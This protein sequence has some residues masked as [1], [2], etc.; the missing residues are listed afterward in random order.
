M[1]CGSYM[2][3]QPYACSATCVSLVI[4]GHGLSLLGPPFP[5]SG[6]RWIGSLSLTQPAFGII[7]PSPPQP[8]ILSLSSGRYKVSIDAFC[9]WKRVPFPCLLSCLPSMSH[10]WALNPFLLP[11][12]FLGSVSQGHPSLSPGSP[13]AQP[14]AH[15]PTVVVYM[16]HFYFLF[17]MAT[18][19]CCWGL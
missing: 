10:P 5:H 1:V 4:P 3:S 6:P 15:D 17:P 18:E 12:P 11:D 2:L 16:A 7:A 13:S 19:L 9:T 8:H 14:G